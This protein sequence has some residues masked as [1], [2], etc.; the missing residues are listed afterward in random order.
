MTA[1]VGTTLASDTVLNTSIKAISD[2]TTRLA[3]EVASLSLSTIDEIQYEILNCSYPSSFE[4]LMKALQHKDFAASQLLEATGDLLRSGM[5]FASQSAHD[6][7]TFPPQLR[8]PIRKR[9]HPMTLYLSIAE[10]CNLRCEYCSAGFGRFGHDPK[11]ME[12]GVAQ[13]A[14]DLLLE[15]EEHGETRGLIFA[16]GEPLLNK[17]VLFFAIDYAARRA[18][19]MGQRIYFSFNTNGTLMTEEVCD[20]L[21]RHQVYAT[22]SIDGT[23]AAHDQHRRFPDGQGTYDIAVRNFRSYCQKMKAKHGD[24]HPRVQCCLPRGEGFYRA[25]ENLKDL[26]ASI[27]VINPAW[28]SEFLA[29]GLEM[30]PSHYRR[31]LAEYDRILADVLRQFQEGSAPYCLMGSTAESITQLDQ[32]RARSLGCGAGNDGFAITASGDI[33]P[34]A[35]LMGNR[36]FRI[37]DVFKGVSLDAIEAVQL[38]VRSTAAKCECCWARSMC[39]AACLAMAVV[40][41]PENEA[42]PTRYC[43][44]FRGYVE[45]DILLFAKLSANRER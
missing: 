16:G 35:L 2:G 12:P 33:Y 38:K 7:Q 3:F 44:L 39:G 19:S 17:N 21:V 40:Q 9:F 6:R 41:R 26:G 15:T 34:C 30:H 4:S 5:L 29:H 24:F 28:R 31:Y 27:L 36:E 8:T 18:A 20:F 43:D 45:R 23:K 22:F 32:R 25:Y 13:Q 1:D 37:G 42:E 11:L 10:D 14:L